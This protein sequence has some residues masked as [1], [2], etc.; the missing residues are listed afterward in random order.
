MKP[1]NNYKKTGKFTNKW[2]LNNMILNNQYI[3]EEIKGNLKIP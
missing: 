3:K 1:E 2:G